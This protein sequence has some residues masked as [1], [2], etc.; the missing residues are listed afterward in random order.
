MWIGI[1][2]ET[3]KVVKDTIISNNCIIFNCNNLLQDLFGDEE[4]G[5]QS[6]LDEIGKLSNF[7]F[8]RNLNIFHFIICH[9]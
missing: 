9:D 4:I 7:N 5:N 6:P 8:H 2:K 1:C 3:A